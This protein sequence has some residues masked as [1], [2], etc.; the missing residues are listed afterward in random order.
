MGVC[1]V[2]TFVAGCITCAATIA[3]LCRLP[4]DVQDETIP[5]ILGGG[6]VMV[7]CDSS[8]AMVY[9]YFM[10]CLRYLQ[11]AETGSGKTGAFALPAIQIVHETRRGVSSSASRAAGTPAKRARIEEPLRLNLNDRSPFLA[12]AEDG[13]TCQCRQPTQWGGVRA[14]RGVYNGRYYYEARINDDGLCRFGWSTQAGSLDLGTDKHG[15]GF[16]GT[17]KKSNDRKFDTYGAEFA[18][19]MDTRCCYCRSD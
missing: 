16:G 11:A 19:G 14:N 4:S 9:I 5:L 10:S 15:F 17:G 1:F 2:G 12:I 13:L 18:K 3:R 7:V 6:D 8:K